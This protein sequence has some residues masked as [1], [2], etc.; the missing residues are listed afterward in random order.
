MC[1][2][3]WHVVNVQYPVFWWG[4]QQSPWIINVTIN[5]FAVPS[6]TIRYHKGLTILYIH[7]TQPSV[8]IPHLSKFNHTGLTSSMDSGGKSYSASQISW[9]NTSLIQPTLS[10]KTKR[11]KSRL[12]S[13]MANCQIQEKHTNNW[14]VHVF[15]KWLLMVFLLLPFLQDFYF[16][17]INQWLEGIVSKRSLT[18]TCRRMQEL[19]QVYYHHLVAT[20]LTSP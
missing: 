18:R 17:R 10:G 20:I 15:Q 2:D 9:S 5:P 1:H 19:L 14:V 4:L 12:S 11:S 16:S 6:E 3:V 8:N 13:G 7:P